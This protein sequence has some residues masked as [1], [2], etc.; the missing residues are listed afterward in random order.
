MIDAEDHEAL[1]TWAQK[2]GGTALLGFICTLLI[3]GKFLHHAFQ[4]R[5]LVFGYFI[6]PPALISGLL[7][8]V[9][10]SVMAKFDEQVSFISFCCT[11]YGCLYSCI[12]SDMIMY[13]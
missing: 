5:G 3:C 8:L 1:E 13:T 7:G 6:V 9:W 10:C 12:L 11:C 4:Q 2:F